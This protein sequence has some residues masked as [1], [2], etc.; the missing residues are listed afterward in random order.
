MKK[1]NLVAKVF[2]NQAKERHKTKGG[3]WNFWRE[4]LYPEK[5]YKSDWCWV[6][7]E[8]RRI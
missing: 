7:G 5:K 2:G 3:A 6:M 8:E 1:K 4:K